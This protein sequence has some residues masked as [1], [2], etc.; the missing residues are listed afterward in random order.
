MLSPP[1]ATGKFAGNTGFLDTPVAAHLA[2]APR[3]HEG[4]PKML[5]FASYIVA[6]D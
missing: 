5:R 2:S 6:P 1:A 4:E 3:D